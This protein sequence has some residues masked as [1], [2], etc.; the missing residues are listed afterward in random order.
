VPLFRLLYVSDRTR[1]IRSGGARHGEG[2]RLV[3]PNDVVMA[4]PE[5]PLIVNLVCYFCDRTGSDPVAESPA[6]T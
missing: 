5:V 2:V 3:I 6:R 4:P 1:A